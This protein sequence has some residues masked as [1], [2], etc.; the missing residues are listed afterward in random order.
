MYVPAFRAQD[1]GKG[2]VAGGERSVAS[3]CGRRGDAVGEADGRTIAIV[4]ACPD[5]AGLH[6]EF[7]R[8]GQHG[9][10]SMAEQGKIGFYLVRVGSE[11]TDHLV[12]HLGRIDRC[13][14]GWG[15]QQSGYLCG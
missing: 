5:P 9:H 3:E 1:S 13:K 15:T 14:Q 12:T 10:A 8:Y 7:I 2:S 6:A 4:T 11:D